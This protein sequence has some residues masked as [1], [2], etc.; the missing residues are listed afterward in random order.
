MNKSILNIALGAASGLLVGAAASYFVTKTVL[1]RKYEA[2][3]YQDMDQ[4]REY[5]SRLNDEGVTLPDAVIEALQED[6]DVQRDRLIERG[7]LLVQAAD[8]GYIGT[9]ETVESL[10][11]REEIV[12]SE[13]EG[14]PSEVEYEKETRKIAIEEEIP[15]D[16]GSD[17][18]QSLV[19]RRNPSQAYV[20][21]VD[22]YHDEMDGTYE[23]QT[24]TWFAGDSVLM[25]TSEK[26]QNDVGALL[27]P[28]AL[29]YFGK[30]SQ[31]EHIVYV[32]NERLGID[33]EVIRD[34]QSYTD[35][36]VNNILEGD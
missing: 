27:G 17:E 14:H 25:D 2:R 3:L 33:F 22:E 23:K 6:P 19:A 29:E 13:V 4:V 20:I 35:V 5:W 24:L 32:R 36:M 31:D 11:A 26:I 12:L 18:F 8:L 1:T 9:E 10:E 15:V 28:D 7:R 34:D 30:F 16:H 21:S